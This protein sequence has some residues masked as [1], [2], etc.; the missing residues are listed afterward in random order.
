MT[1]DDA[2]EA[3]GRTTAPQSPYGRGELLVGF[4]VLAVGAVVAF[5]IPLVL[6]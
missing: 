2:T 6:A 3:T 5:G 1:A 4:A